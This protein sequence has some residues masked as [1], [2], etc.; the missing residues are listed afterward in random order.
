MIWSV[1][2]IIVLA[3]EPVV[4]ILSY[5]KLNKRAETLDYSG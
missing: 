3:V 4:K 1:F 2:L 5:M